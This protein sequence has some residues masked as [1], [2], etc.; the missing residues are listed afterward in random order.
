MG[1]GDLI[2]QQWQQ[3]QPLLPHQKPTTGRSA[4]GHRTI[5]NGILYPAPTAGQQASAM[6]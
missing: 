6:G 2:D 3:L 5:I 4:K 1:R